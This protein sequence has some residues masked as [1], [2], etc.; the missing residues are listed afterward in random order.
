MRMLHLI[1]S[2]GMYGA[3]AVV[4]NLTTAQKEQSHEPVIG[5]LHNR[6]RPHLEIAAEARKRGLAVEIFACQGRFDRSTV[7][8]IRDFVTANS[9]EVVHTHGYKSDIYGRFAVKGLNTAFVATCHLWTRS[10]RSVRFYEFLDSLILRSARRVVGVSDAI[11]EAL[12]Q[13]GIPETKLATVYNGTDLSRFE[14]PVRTLRDELGIGDGLLIGTVGR[15]ETQ[16]GIEYFIRAAREVLGEFPA[17]QFVVIGEGSLRAQLNGLIRDLRLGANIRLLGERTDMPGVYAS[18][19]LFVL[20]SIDEGMPMTILEALASS[21]PVL[22]TR[23]GAVDKL[24]VP[25]IT[26]LLMESKDVN[27]LRDAMLRCLRD[28]DFARML[29]TNGARHVRNSFSAGAMA[30]NYAEIYS[31]ALR[32]GEPCAIPVCQGS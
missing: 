2:A 22:A 25:D 29:G 18:L 9:I 4:L 5:V 10:T 26:G 24:V 20:A 19:D 27:A 30:S 11:T 6:H 16:K 31:Q 12:A 3:E 13:S 15:L 21:R 17:A 23:V 28:P 14:A 1:S 8:S 32:A 7:R